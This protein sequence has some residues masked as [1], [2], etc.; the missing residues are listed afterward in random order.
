MHVLGI[1]QVALC[2]CGYQVLDVIL[3]KDL[4]QESNVDTCLSDVL[5]N[6]PVNAKPTLSSSTSCR[7]KL[8]QPILTWSGTHLKTGTGCLRGTTCLVCEGL[9]HL[10]RRVLSFDTSQSPQQFR[11]RVLIFMH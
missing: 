9:I 5:S 10:M 4:L 8:R 2:C 3:D 6:E 1:L 11:V 7:D